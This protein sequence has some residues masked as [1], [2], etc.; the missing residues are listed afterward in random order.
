MHKVR[1]CN[2]EDLKIL[3]NKL[4]YAVEGILFAAGE[5]VKT[6]QLAAALECGIKEIEEAVETLKDEYNSQR[7]GF[8]IIDI[9]E[10]YQICSRPE[11]YTYIQVILG[12]QRRQA[13]SNAAMETLAIIAYKQ[14][15]TKGS[16]EY[17]RGI[18][19]DGSVNRLLERGLVEEKGRLNAPGRPILYGTTVNF[20]RC[21]GLAD[22]SDLPTVDLSKIA[23]GVEDVQQEDVL[24]GEETESTETAENLN[25]N[26]ESE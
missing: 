14:P 4:K 21:F 17:I 6:A 8:A 12:E 3:M 2:R 11:Y 20:L 7:R 26:S 23:E 16:I 18:N 25:Q 5:P 10:G 19:S 24:T 9:D 1:Q 15:V 13:L 22:L